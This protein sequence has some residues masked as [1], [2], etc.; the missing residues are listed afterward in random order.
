MIDASGLSSRSTVVKGVSVRLLDVIAHRDNLKIL[1]GDVGNAFVNAT[2]KERV[3]SRAGPEFGEKEGLIVLLVKALY[4]L[5]T[6][7]QRWRSVFPD[8]F[9]SM[10]FYPS[11]YDR[12]VWL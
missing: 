7:A 3:Y 4:G 10:G 9:R 2:T 1:C 5:R 6:S 12:D 8:F 11:R